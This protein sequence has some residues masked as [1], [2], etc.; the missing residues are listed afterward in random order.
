MK[1]SGETLALLRLRMTPGLGPVLIER[2]LA[3]HGSAERAIEAAEQHGAAAFLGIERIGAGRARDLAAALPRTASEAEQEVG[4]LERLGASLVGLT[5]AGYPALLRTIPAAPPVLSVRGALDAEKDRLSVAVVGSRGCSAYGAEQAAR[6]ASALGMAGLTLESGGARGIDTH[7]HEAAL[8]A[9]ART[10]VVLGCGLAECYPP[11]NK[12]LFDAVVDAGGA[13]ISELPAH[14]APEAKNFPARNRIIS[15]MS[16]GTLVIEAGAKSGAL[17]TARVAAEDQGRE[18]LVVPGRVDSAASAGCLDLIRAGAGLAVTPA[19]VLEALEA[20][21]RH[22]HASTHA[23]RYGGTD[24]PPAADGHAAP[25]GLADLTGLSGTQRS[26]CDA[27]AEPKTL[28]ELARET[29]IAAEVLRA[30]ATMLEIRR[31][32]VREGARLRLRDAR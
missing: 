9:G 15:G 18:V 13:V 27:L 22:A 25:A 30:E 11:E 32:V 3:R 19:D 31:V 21:A 1:C 29:G 12:A 28:D 26:M 8:R 4:A 20:P 6:F 14:A 16:L 5:D 2:V 7:A 10:V 17:I 24:E 23:P